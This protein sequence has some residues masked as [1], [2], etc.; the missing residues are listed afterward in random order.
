[1][2]ATIQQHEPVATGVH[3]LDL[4]GNFLEFQPGQFANL[5]VPGFYLRRPFAIADQQ[6]GALT[7][8][9]KVVGDGTQAMSDWPIGCEVDI[10]SPLGAGFSAKGDVPLLVGGGAGVGPLYAQAKALRALDKP[11]TV[12]LG[13]RTAADAY[14][15]QEFA[16]LGCTLLVATEDGSLGTKGFVTAAIA[17]ITADYFYTC[18]PTPMMQAVCA[19]LAI[20]GEVSLEERMACGFGACVG[21]AVETHEGMRRVCKDGPVFPREVLTW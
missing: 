3:R 10:L 21:C 5:S 16:D 13:F 19:A 12:A 4:A 17:D 15:T 14:L 6:N 2:K 8:Y 11:V 20:S 1:M 7:I 9:Y 18:G